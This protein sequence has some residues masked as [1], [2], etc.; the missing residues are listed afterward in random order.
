M[1]TASALATCIFLAAQTYQVPPAVL[2]GIM[3][4]E[5]GKVG[6]EVSNTNG[7]H[8]LGPMQINTIWLEELSQKWNVSKSKA[9]SWVRDDECVNIGV[10]AWILRRQINYA[11]TL[12]GGIARYHSGTPHIGKRYRQKV[13]AAMQNAGLLTKSNDQ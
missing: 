1:I 6:Q 3:K 9:R 11:G 4:V 10:A 7:S 13:I 8:D 2:I 12:S 5:G